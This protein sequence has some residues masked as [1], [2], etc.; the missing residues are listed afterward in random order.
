M[1]GKQRNAFLRETTDVEYAFPTAV[2]TL[3]QIMLTTATPSAYV[4]VA[5]TTADGI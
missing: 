3:K 5:L 4:Q 1:N 2:Y